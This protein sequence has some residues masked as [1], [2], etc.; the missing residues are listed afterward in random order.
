MAEDSQRNFRSVYYEKVGFRGVEEKK[1]LEILLKDDRLDIEKLCTFSQR[2]PL[3]SMYR[4]LV[5][6]VLLGIIPPHH[7]S[8]TLVMKYRTEQ[9]RD[10]YH[11]LQVIRFIKDF[12]PQVEVF[13]RMHQLESGR[14]PRNLAFPLEPEDEVFLAI[15]KAMEEV[16]EDNIDCYWL[17]SSFV[18]QLNNKY[19]DSLPQLPKVLEQY[20]NV[21][22]NRL[23]AHL[24]ACSAVSKL[25]YNLWF[26]KCFAGCLPESSL[27]RVWDK[28]I[29]GSCKILV[30][31]AL[32]ILLTFKMKIMAL[33]NAEK[34]T[35][36]LENIPQDNTDAIVSKAIDLWHK[37]CG[38][39][40]HLV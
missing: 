20:L 37:H 33:T 14:L 40:V 21:E 30:F 39:P 22:D 34:I 35:Q 11:A 2:F 8:H 26:K 25:P 4:I 18:N 29:S 38:M 13:L 7:E 10:V 5:W 23:L 36:F 17:V 3:P 28:V 16:V 12:T 31:V 24:K 1:S 15:A 27:Q 19:K 6:K 32:E 9:Y